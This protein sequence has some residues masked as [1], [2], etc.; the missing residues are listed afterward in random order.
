MCFTRFQLLCK[1]KLAY[2]ILN[3]KFDIFFTAFLCKGTI[4]NSLFR[5]Y[6][7]SNDFLIFS[8]FKFELWYLTT[9]I[10]L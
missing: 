5:Y 2:F 4:C 8:S 7:P 9:T 1:A 10:Y 6:L 3:S